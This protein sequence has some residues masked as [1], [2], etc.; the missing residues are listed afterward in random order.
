MKPNKA[1]ADEFYA[2]FDKVTTVGDA[3]KPGLIGDALREANS[4]AYVF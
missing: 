1:L 4:K 2:A 3:S